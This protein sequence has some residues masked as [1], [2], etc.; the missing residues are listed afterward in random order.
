MKE[1]V[2]SALARE[3][4]VEGERLLIE[5]PSV[6]DALE[7]LASYEGYLEGQAS[8]EGVFN[9]V[10]CRWLPERLT[11]LFV[12]EDVVKRVVVDHVLKFVL[13]GV[14]EPEKAKTKAGRT[15]KSPFLSMVGSYCRTYG[16]DPYTVY[17]TTPWPF[18]LL[19]ASEVRRQ[20]AIT[21]ITQM[22]AF[23]TTHMKK[24]AHAKMM[25][26]IES[27]MGIIT[28]AANEAEAA[29]QGLE[30]LQA[31]KEEQDARLRSH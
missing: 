22:K 14:P 10:L 31:L 17:C 23:S 27:D 25:R 26:E 11:D 5:P 1:I 8:A 13:E 29:R 16:T 2:R 9:D 30:M 12:R 28:E 19:F 18:F 24:D 21:Q 4:E 6:R 7:I 3:R 20:A 15:M